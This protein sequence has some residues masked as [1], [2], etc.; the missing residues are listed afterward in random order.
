MDFKAIL[1]ASYR[2][3]LRRYIEESSEVA[4]YQ[5]QM[6]S[7][8]SIEHKVSPEE[9][10]HIHC[11]VLK[12]LF[13]DIQKEV[14]SSFDFLM[15]FMMDYGLAYQEHQSLRNRQFEIISEIETAASIQENLLE[16]PVPDHDEL[17]IGAISVPAK[18]MNGDF[19]QFVHERERI[20]IAIADIIG[21]GIPAALCMSMIKYAMDSL[22][23][24][25]KIP[26]DVLE[27]L[28]KVVEGNVG[29]SMFIT[30]FYGIYDSVKHLFTYAAAGHE[31]GFYYHSLTDTF[32][33]L[34]TEGIVLG[35]DQDVTYKQYEKRVEPGDMLV[36]LSDGVTESKT[37]EGFIERSAITD[38]IQ[39][40]MHLSSQEMVENIYHDI[41]RM[42]NFELRDDFT[43][44]ILR[45][46]Q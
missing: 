33:D 22:S 9:I 4:L 14:L 38:L 23:E 3:M 44:I 11:K 18:K 16:T 10:I 5:G 17:D 19:H 34:I 32:E 2:E 42:Q 20:S 36:L 24:S 21:K 6:F 35:V 8:K 45:R 40:Y 26:K 27:Y 29:S 30:M 46:K 31:Q 13:P 25:T 28:N 37:D 12:D 7:R 39:T 41:E 15:E 43:L 1:E